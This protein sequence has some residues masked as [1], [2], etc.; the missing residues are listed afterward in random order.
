MKKLLYVVAALIVLLVVGVVVAVSMVNTDDIKALLVEKTKES[1]GREL[2]I[3][4]DLA[5]RFFPSIGFELGSLRLRDNPEFGDG[6]TVSITGAEM[7][8]ALMPLFSKSIE[9][10]DISVR[11][12][13]LRYQTKADGTTS[14]DDLTQSKEA[15]PASSEPKSTEESSG[16]SAAGWSVRLAGIEIVDANVELIDLTLNKTQKLGPVNFTLDGLELG[17]DN[18]FSLS[19]KFDDGEMLVEQQATGLLF[20][21]EDFSRIALSDVSNG[22]NLQ[23]SA[24][25]NGAMNVQTDL[26]LSYTVASKTAE[27]SKLAVDIDG[28][29]QLVGTSSVVLNSIPSIKFDLNIPLLDTSNFISESSASSNTTD[30]ANASSEAPGQEQEP[31]LTV[32]KTLNL[33]GTL[34]IDK[35]Q[36]QKLHIEDIKQQVQIKDGILRLK[37]LSANLYDGRLESNAVINGQKPVAS[38][39]MTAKLNGVQARPLLSDAADFDFVA[40]GLN[41]DL[42]VKGTGLTPTAIKK[43]ISG[44]INATF[45][46]GAIYGVNIPQ[47][48]RSAKATIKGG[49]KQQAQQEQ[50][51]D[52]SE[53]VIISTL[54]KSLAK[55]NKMQMSSPLLRIDGTGQTHLIN[56]SLDFTFI[57]K[58]VASLEGQ[59]SKNDLAGLDI[60]INVKGSWTEPKVN[61]DM[62]K[63]FEGQAKEA[64]N[65]EL[66]KALGDNEDSKKLLDSLGGFFN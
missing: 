9:V 13:A 10:G 5:W 16:A 49:D 35:L 45:T 26:A 7:S 58:V 38:Y 22:L 25:P 52:F 17:E 57:T 20:I 12:L 66:K 48:I 42:D 63:L 4:G 65:K 23:G 56:E 34:T 55:V 14:L 43:K 1:T 64:V 6:D 59:G 39:S 44:P 11:G 2:V 30:D 33:D 8:V 21:A 40:G 15:E 32:L 60:P 62:K 31:D 51:T 46:D 47:M 19:L 50:K 24:I 28:K 53:L 27:L 3:D 61:L 18:G 37:E 41:V 29:T 54:G 36:H